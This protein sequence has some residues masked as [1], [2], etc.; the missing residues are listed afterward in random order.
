MKW[1]RFN[2][3]VERDHLHIK[4]RQRDVQIWTLPCES[5]LKFWCVVCVI[6]LMMDPTNEQGFLR[7]SIGSELV[8]GMHGLCWRSKSKSPWEASGQAQATQA[9]NI[10]RLEYVSRQGAQPDEGLHGWV[11]DDQANYVSD[12]P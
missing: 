6:W 7:E 1:W 5:D 10:P 9:T 4:A 8:L 2:N 12:R 11:C 3:K